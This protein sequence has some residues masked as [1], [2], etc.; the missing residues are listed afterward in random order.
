MQ[1]TTEMIKELR[2][3]TGAGVLDC[4]NALQ[5]TGG[6]LDKATELLRQKGIAVAA[7]KAGREAREGIIGSYVHMGAKVAALVEL[8]CETDFVART[9]E[10]Q[11]LA[12]DLA[13]QVV[14]T[15]P[16]YVSPEDVPAEVIERE[17]ETYRAQMADSGKPE[18]IIERIVEGKLEKFY[19]ETCLLRQ[20]F[21]RD[22]GMTV[23]DLITD[24]IARLGENIVVRRFIRYEL[25][26]E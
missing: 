24:A 2:A 25:G 11:Q 18:H 22:E 1:V 4:R 10:F 23:Q 6:D 9:P 16:L 7:K 3:R 19:D 15:R 13:M 26:E 20:P 5:E 21:I 14:A 12:K 8:N 17:K